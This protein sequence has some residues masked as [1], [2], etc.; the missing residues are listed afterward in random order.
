MKLSITTPLAMVVEED[1][2]LSLRAEDASGGFGIQPG[3]ADFLTRL[4][5]GVVAWT[6]ADKRRRYCA[7]RGGVLS[8]SGGQQI[9]I[10]TRE[11]VTGDDIATLDQE[12]LA[13]FRADRER[14]R[15]EHVAGTR[16]QLDAVRQ[17]MM[18]L[19]AQSPRGSGLFS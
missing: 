8:V 9:A 18:H 10:A 3:H 16:L 15:S 13:R 19:R 6:G 1:A 2:V 11:A 12:V 4:G 17:L 5:I 7:V 14:Q